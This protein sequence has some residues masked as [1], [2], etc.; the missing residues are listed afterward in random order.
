MGELDYSI[1]VLVNSVMSSVSAYDTIKFKGLNN[2]PLAPLLYIYI[3][4]YIYIYNIYCHGNFE[5]NNEQLSIS[6]FKY[7]PCQIIFSAACYR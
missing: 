1:R 3:Y 5:R 4:I 7:A 6:F 2:F